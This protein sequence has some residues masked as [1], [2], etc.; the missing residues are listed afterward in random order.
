MK[1][2]K[3]VVVGL[4]SAALMASAVFAIA[5][6]DSDAIAERLQ[7]VGKVCMAGDDCAGGASVVAAGEPRSGEEIYT[8]KC[9]ACHNA[10]VGGAPKI[11]DAGDWEARVAQG[12][13]V[14]FDHA[15]NGFNAMPPKGICMDC[16]EDEMKATIEHMIP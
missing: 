12:M 6:G 5:A 1:Q 11:G 7:P 8:T 9:A 14:L 15:W 10:G 4:M 16:T 13:D 2:L 3:K